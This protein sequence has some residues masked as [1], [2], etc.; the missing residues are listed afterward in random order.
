M[1]IYNSFPL[2]SLHLDISDFLIKEGD[3]IFGEILDINEE[4]IF[5][6]LEN[7]GLVKGENNI[8]I[9]YPKSGR[10]KFLVKSI[11]NEKIELSPII[12]EKTENLRPEK[13]E[14]KKIID[15]IFREY[16]ILQDE[17][18]EEFVESLLD[19]NIP[20]NKDNVLKGL[21][22]IKKLEWI[23]NKED[24]EKIILFNTDKEPMKEEIEKFIIVNKE[25]YNEMK[26]L[27]YIYTKVK[28]MF[29]EGELTSW[30]I[31]SIAFILKNNMNISINNLEKIFCIL[32][33]REIISREVFEFFYDE[34]ENKGDSLIFNNKNFID[35]IGKDNSYIK[36]YYKDLNKKIEYINNKIKNNFLKIDNDT[37]KNIEK[38]GDSLKFLEEINKEMT[39]VYV[40]IFADKEENRGSVSMFK[41]ANKNINKG[42]KLNVFINLDMDYL[43]KV[44]IYCEAFDNL[45]N[46]SFNIEKK[47]IYLFKQNEEILYNLIRESGYK[48]NAVNYIEDRDINLLDTLSDNQNPYYYLDVRV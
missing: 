41:K 40:P 14:N 42:D 25:E 10:I 4:L 22:T 33:G 32:K 29:P 19:Y 11:Y 47:D 5:L 37:K 13:F 16:N 39:F 17:I 31:K 1:Y 9:K 38:L 28:D 24:G 7:I 15:K 2:E 21:K 27:D 43:N 35:I 6:K 45:L 44:K 46:I 23:L 48:L 36:N 30:C 18:S 12:N 26:S 8:N 3:I 20:L 34:D